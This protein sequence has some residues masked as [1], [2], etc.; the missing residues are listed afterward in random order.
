MN[1]ARA[2]KI[3]AMPNWISDLV[4]IFNPPDTL[5]PKRH[6]SA[7]HKYL[8]GPANHRVR[9]KKSRQTRDHKHYQNK[10]QHFSSYRFL[11]LSS[12]KSF[13]VIARFPGS[14]RCKSC[15]RCIGGIVSSDRQAVVPANGAGIETLC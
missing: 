13:R 14:S 15:L 1:A 3:K 4:F 6:Q 2:R 7:Y 10:P 8:D 12:T 5:D 9:S 11:Q